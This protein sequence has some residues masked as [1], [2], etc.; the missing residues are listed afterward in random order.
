MPDGRGTKTG[1]GFQE[2]GSCLH[3]H[4]PPFSHALP[5][6][7]TLFPIPCL[8]PW[9]CCLCIG[10]T[11]PHPKHPSAASFLCGLQRA[12][13]SP[14]GQWSFGAWSP[15][16]TVQERGSPSPQTPHAPHP[17]LPAL[18]M[19]V[20]FYSFFFL[21]PLKVCSSFQ[22]GPTQ[23]YNSQFMNQP[24]PRGPA[25]MGG[26]MNPASMAAGMTPSGMSGPPM[27]MNQPRPPGISPFGT[28]GQRMPQQTYPGPRPQ[29][30]PIQSIKRPYPGEVSVTAGGWWAGGRWGGAGA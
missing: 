22:M 9:K 30:L 10:V 11:A 17:S 6:P 21:L 28:H 3:P 26:S 5:H 27:G 13:V 1:P 7:C 2:R 14:E 18:S 8:P 24:G 23:A 19:H 25:S 15:A 16:A 4:P 20:A 29:S 12:A